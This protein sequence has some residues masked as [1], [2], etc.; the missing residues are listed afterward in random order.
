MPE[1]S[2]IEGNPA[3]GFRQAY[4]RLMKIPDAATLHDESMKLIM[5]YMNKGVSPKNCNKFRYEIARIKDNL[6]QM[7]MLIS[8]FIL[9][10]DGNGVIR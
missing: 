9:K 10:A 3:H 7:Q 5:S 8:N 1:L 4:E 6:P 2:T